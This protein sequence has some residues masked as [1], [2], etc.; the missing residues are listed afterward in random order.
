MQSA[1]FREFSG[2]YIAEDCQFLSKSQSN[3]DAIA[4]GMRRLKK[5]IPGSMPAF[6]IAPVTFGRTASSRSSSDLNRKARNPE[7]R[8]IMKVPSFFA[9][10]AIASSLALLGSPAGAKDPSASSY[11]KKAR[12]GDLELKSAGRLAFGPAG[13]LLVSDP[14]SASIVAIDTGDTGPVK[15]LSGPIEDI[16]T[17]LTEA[18]GAEKIKIVDMAVNP[19]SGRIYFS[20]SSEP[21][22]PAPPPRGK[23]RGRH[24]RS[25]PFRS[26]PCADPLAGR[27]ERATP[28]CHR[29]GVDRR[30]RDCRRPVER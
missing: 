12:T 10:L 18:A 22:K 7:T 17:L 30:L 4:A 28:Q 25:R 6:T 2:T 11:F 27:G 8:N 20:L 3:L 16:E 15:K 14:R 24:R 29:L 23:R 1:D 19:A 5:E 21:G 26:A 13:M 9:G